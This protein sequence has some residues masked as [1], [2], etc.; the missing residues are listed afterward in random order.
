[1]GPVDYP[2]Q[3]AWMPIVVTVITVINARYSPQ[4]NTYPLG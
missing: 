1:M 3:H 2:D 4:T